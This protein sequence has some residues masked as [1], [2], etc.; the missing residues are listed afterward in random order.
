MNKYE[1]LLDLAAQNGVIVRENKVFKS[2][3][4]GLIKGNIIG[5]SCK[6]TN[7]RQ[8]ACILAEELGHY[9]TTVGNIIDQRSVSNRKQEKTARL[10]AFKKLLPLS[11]I[12]ESILE[13]C[14]TIAETALYADVTD[15]FVYE[16]IK[17][18]KAIYGDEAL[19]DEYVLNL[20][21]LMLK[22]EL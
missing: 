15:E 13:G 10:W 8:R 20:N 19:V 5:L 17:A 11:L 21:N 18:Y 7:D 22:K 3:C 1:M 9:F 4:L 2:D 12:V 6:L 16:A 14:N